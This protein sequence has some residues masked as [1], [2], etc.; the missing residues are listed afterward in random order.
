MMK[1]WQETNHCQSRIHCRSC[2]TSSAFREKIKSSF[3]EIICPLNLEINYSGDYPSNV[4][5]ICKY[6]H[7]QD[8]PATNCRPC[9]GKAIICNC[10]EIIESLGF[11]KQKEAIDGKQTFPPNMSEKRCR[12]EHC[13]YFKTEET[14]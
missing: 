9:H 11:E 2:R 1:M 8:Y 10:P 5:K 14:T 7:I 13:K 3:G 4:L 12:P 6:M